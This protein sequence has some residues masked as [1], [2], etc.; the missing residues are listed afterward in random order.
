MAGKT[1]QTPG[2]NQLAQADGAVAVAGMGTTTNKQYGLDLRRCAS[3]SGAEK[4]SCITF[5]KQRH[6]DL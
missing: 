2:A 3:M 6:G 1:S 5:A 4:A